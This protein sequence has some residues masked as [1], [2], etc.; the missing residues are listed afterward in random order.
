MG[1]KVV[2]T[3]FGRQYQFISSDYG[4]VVKFRFLE[5]I[6][7]DEEAGTYSLRTLEEMKC[8]AADA[9]D[10]VRLYHLEYK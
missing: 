6:C 8:H 5:Y 1:I 10:H 3:P 2:S 9:I 4:W 7:S